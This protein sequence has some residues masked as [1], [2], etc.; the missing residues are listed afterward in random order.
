[1]LERMSLLR[2]DPDDARRLFERARTGDVDAQY[3]LGLSYAEGRG[4][5]INEAKS[6]FWLSQACAQGDAEANILRNIVA[7]DMSE[8]DFQQ[9]RR[10]CDTPD[11]IRRIEF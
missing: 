1:M 3:A 7:R 2:N 8:T 10:L 9:A 11:Y 6:Y 4:V 5:A